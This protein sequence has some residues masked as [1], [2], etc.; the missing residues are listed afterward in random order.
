MTR[1]L[2]DPML[3]FSRAWPRPAARLRGGAEVG[4]LPRRVL[5]RSRQGTDMTPAFPEIRTAALAQLPDDTGLDG[6]LAV[7]ETARLV[8][9][10]LQ[11]ASPAAAVPVPSRPRGP[12]LLTTSSSTCCTCTVQT[13]PPGDRMDQVGQPLPVVVGLVDRV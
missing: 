10:R 1:M 6:G 9:E 5:L 3:T 2:P 8:F 7:W 12:G 13:V 11:H 4:R